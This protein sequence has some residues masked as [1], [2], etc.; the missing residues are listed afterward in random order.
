MKCMHMPERVSLWTRLRR[1]IAHALAMP[2]PLELTDSDAE[3]IAKVANMIV[4]RRLATPAMM[5]LEIAR[6]LNF[7][8]S[9][10]MAFLSPFATMILNREEYDR[11][12]QILEHRQAVDALVDA[13]SRSEAARSSADPADDEE[14]EAAGGYADG[15][16]PPSPRTQM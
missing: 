13:I 15:A 8:A 2:P 6:P 5:A 4:R 3:L 1:E 14:S 11:F 16:D 9:Q 10:F 12:A 7:V